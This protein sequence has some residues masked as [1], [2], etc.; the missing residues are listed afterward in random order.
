MTDGMTLPAALTA[1]ADEV[2]AAVFAAAETR[3]TDILYVR[4]M[5]R[6]IMLIIKLIPETVFKRLQIG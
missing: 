4:W 5:W 1:S 2:G 3:R 6:F